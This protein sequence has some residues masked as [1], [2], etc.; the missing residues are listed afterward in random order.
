MIAGCDVLVLPKPVAAD[1]ARLPE[2]TALWGWVHCVQDAEITQLAID[3]RLTLI[4]WE[5]MHRRNGDGSFALHVFH[6]NNELAGYCSV[7]HALQLSGVSGRYG[8]ELR[9]AVIG[10]GATGR[11]AVAGLAAM[12]VEDVSVLTQRDA[13]AVSGATDSMRL[14]TYDRDP[15][16]G[17]QA[18]HLD[19][20]GEPVARFV[21][22]CDIVVNCVLQDT[23]APLL[24]VSAADL[25]LFQ[26]RTLFVDVSADTGMGFEW[27]RPTSFEQPT[28]AVGAGCR[29]YAVDHS[30]SLLWDSATWEISKALIPHL[31]A[32]LAGPESWSADPTIGPAI[33]IRDGVIANPKILSFQRR[34]A[35]YPHERG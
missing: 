11:G 30:P 12:G 20:G 26:R 13:A 7:I 24:L 27:S 23:D 18:P 33:E 35:A 31:P 15:D 6:R 17:G 16:V 10:Y 21:A 3:R 1:L 28:F 9:A 22:D 32:V 5:E 8:R 4:A 14:V 25:P 19:R 2:G 34:A 29:C